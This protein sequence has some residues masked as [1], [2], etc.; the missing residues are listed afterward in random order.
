[1]QLALD[2]DILD[3]SSTVYDTSGKCIPP[4]YLGTR[5]KPRVI[6][7]LFAEIPFGRTRSIPRYRLVYGG[8]QDCRAVLKLYCGLIFF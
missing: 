1:M 5:F 2:T 3:R 8:E 6:A 7:N 4:L